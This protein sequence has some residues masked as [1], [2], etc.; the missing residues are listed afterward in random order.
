MNTNQDNEQFKAKQKPKY[1]PQQGWI[2][3]TITSSKCKQA[4]F[5]NSDS[6]K[7]NVEKGPSLVYD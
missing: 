3:A 7:Q 1:Q 2:L 4:N 5:S 6:E